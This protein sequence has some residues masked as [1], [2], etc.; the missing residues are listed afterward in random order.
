MFQ[1]IKAEQKL[2]KSLELTEEGKEIAERGSHEALLYH[3][4]PPDGMSQ[5]ELMVNLPIILGD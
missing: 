3:V 4:L 5:A 1:I 2:N